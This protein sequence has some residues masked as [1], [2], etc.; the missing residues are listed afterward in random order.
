MSF[1]KYFKIYVNDVFSRLLRSDYFMA[2]LLFPSSPVFAENPIFLKSFSFN[3]F[4]TFN[5]ACYILVISMLIKQIILDTNDMSFSILTCWHF[6]RL[7]SSSYF[8]TA[9]EVFP[10]PSVY[11]KNQVLLNDDVIMQ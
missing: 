5:D 9:F 4:L 7:L 3:F 6:L 2:S 10:S 1:K 8:F 11:S